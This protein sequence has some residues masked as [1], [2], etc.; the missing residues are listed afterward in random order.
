MKTSRS[1]RFARLTAIAW[2]A[3][4]VLGCT[5]VDVHETPGVGKGQQDNK[6]TVR[7]N[8]C[9][10]HPDEMQFPVKIMFIIDCSQ[11][12]NVTDPP[13]SPSEYPGRVRAVWEVIQK[14]R[15]D[16]G[17]E[18]ALV[19]FEAAANVATQKDTNGDGI[20]DMFGFVNDLPT[21]LRALNSLQAAGGN[22]SY[23]AGLGLAEATLAMDMANA[24]LD[25]RSRSKYVIIFLS[26]GLPYP[27]DYQT[28]TNTNA[29]ILRTVR[30]MM[31]LAK[32]FEVGD[33]TL[34][35]AFLAVN[36]P[37][38][39]QAQAETLL[40]GMAQAGGGTFRNF[41][42][43]EQINFLDI[44][45]TSIKRMFSVK[46]G[47]F[48][49]SNLNASPSWDPTQGIDTDGD[50]LV[51][52]LELAWG[53]DVGNRDTDGDGFNDYLEYTLRRSGFDPL[54]PDDA[55]CALALDRLDNDGDGLL[56]CEERFL[57]TSPD[58]FDTDADGIPDPVEVRAGTNPVFADADVDLD[59]DGTPNALEVAWHTN[60][61]NNDT[62]QFTKLAY[63][64]NVGRRPGIYESRS[65]YDFE[66]SNITLVGTQPRRPGE[67]SGYNDVMVYAGQAPNDDP[68]DTGIW[69][70]ACARARYVPRYP[71]P[72]IKIPPSGRVTFKQKDF[73][74]PVATACRQNAECP[75]H[76]CEPK[77][78]VCLAPLGERCD[79]NAP[80]A[81]FACVP[82]DLTGQGYC[83]SPVPVACVSQEDCPGYPLHP[84]TGMCLD[85]AGSPPDPLSGQCPRRECESQYFSCQNASQCPGD[86]DTDPNNDPVCVESRCR[87]PCQSAAGCNPGQ[88]CEAA[89]PEEYGACTLPSDCAGPG[90][91]CLDGACR[92]GC[93]LSADCPGPL[94]EC[95]GDVCQSRYCVDHNGGVCARVACGAATDCPRMPCDPEVNRCRTQPCL[96]SRDCPHQDC[97]LAVGF[98]VSTPCEDDRDCRGERGYSC[99]PMVGDP[100]ARDL[101]CPFDFC[102]QR[103]FRC[104]FRSGAAGGTCQI[105][106]DCPA[107]TCD[108][109]RNRCTLEARDCRNDLECTPNL[110]TSFTVCAN[111]PDIGCNMSVDCDQTFCHRDGY[112]LNDLT[113]ACDATRRYQDDDCLVGL[114]ARGEGLGQ[115][116]T[117]ARRPCADDSECP[118]YACNPI[119]GLCVVPIESV[120]RTTPECPAGLECVGGSPP[121]T[122][123]KCQKTCNSDADCP[124]AACQ[125]RC[126]P[127]VPAERKRCTDWFD[128][129]R[130]CL[131][132]D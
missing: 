63:R 34:H 75:H 59:Y 126:Q 102:T 41:Q 108:L 9:T 124:T 43:G 123:G 106:A 81:N 26:D 61:A 84:V 13:P 21:L 50:G 130:D 100:C 74:R 16:P 77:S 72:D 122:W 64:Y 54:D 23:Q 80:C 48:L 40:G 85:P 73:K 2:L 104:T 97:E 49:V 91:T 132:F 39:I 51:D 24:N 109:G 92:R 94:D 44:D 89:G 28:G 83:A 128:P 45:Y 8:F 86:G 5:D 78:R 114:C 107:N 53:T 18:F 99:N 35:T 82:D 60:P 121:S 127:L 46:N 17:V 70:V 25:E 56:N 3:L 31:N 30:E 29:S 66:V 93:V 68:G 95:V 11:S 57:G 32:R 71:E 36:T 79:E 12:M 6:L 55:D 15:N 115:C 14:F 10:E 87:V 38:F 65:C 110:C 125:G 117:A 129:E 69:R 112:C 62:A 19:R 101:D 120:C 58:L 33:M 47:A 27:V 88:T 20:A 1:Y 111:N 52:V 7:G 67:R 4:G 118:P 22:T 37:A 113:R 76:V 116:D 42:N 90:T 105:S 103:V 96:D 98:C 119:S 131:T